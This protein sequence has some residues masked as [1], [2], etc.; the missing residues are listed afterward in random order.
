LSAQLPDR[1]VAAG[2]LLLA[3]VYLYATST[4]PTMEIGDPLGPKAF[5][6]L[7]GILFGLA[8]VLLLFESRAAP[9]G[10]VDEAGG[11]PARPGR[12]AG[13]ATVTIAFFSLLEPLGYLIAFSLYLFVLMVWLHR[14]SPLSCLV[15]AVLFA[16]GS[17][18]LF[19]KA[20]GVALAKG[21]LHF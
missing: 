15:I 4:L 14:R 7:L 2:T 16:L 17:Y 5:P 3:A 6:V 19:A 8:G 1:L 18:A 10:I 11:P 20:L 9:G 13:V 21:L 12:V